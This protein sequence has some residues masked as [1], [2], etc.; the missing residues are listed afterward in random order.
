MAPLLHL[1]S[2]AIKYSHASPLRVENH[3]VNQSASAGLLASTKARTRR[4][5]QEA[6]VYLIHNEV[7]SKCRQTGKIFPNRQF[8]GSN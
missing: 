8:W 5:E 1:V 3:T 6:I 7:I 2:E 4:L